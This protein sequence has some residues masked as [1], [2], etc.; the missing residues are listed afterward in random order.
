MAKA[1]KDSGITWMGEIPQDTCIKKLKYC[2]TILSGYP[3]DSTKFTLTPGFPLIRIR[4]ITSGKI[5]TYYSGEYDISLGEESGVYTPAEP[6]GASKPES[7]NPLDEIIE[8]IN[9]LY[10]GNFTDADRVMIGA[11]AQRLAK[12][13]R[14]RA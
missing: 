6:K 4:D 8:R 2:C 11:L 13:R 12:E 1:M 9:E 5:E 7:K 3:F 10:K 14:N